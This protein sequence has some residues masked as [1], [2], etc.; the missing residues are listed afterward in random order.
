MNF[1]KFVCSQ[2]INFLGIQ[3]LILLYDVIIFFNLLKI[4]TIEI[5]FFIISKK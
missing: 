5:Y 2:F 4:K 1:W 3:N